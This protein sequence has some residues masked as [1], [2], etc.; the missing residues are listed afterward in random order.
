MLGRIGSIVSF[1]CLTCFIGCT[2]TPVGAAP[3]TD[4]ATTISV[5]TRSEYPNHPEVFWISF[6]IVGQVDDVKTW[7]T[8]SGAGLYYNYRRRRFELIGGHATRFAT[9]H[10]LTVKDV[11]QHTGAPIDGEDQ[12]VI[13]ATDFYIYDLE[14]WDDAQSGRASAIFKR[15]SSG[16]YYIVPGFTTRADD[17]GLNCFGLVVL[18]FFP[19]LAEAAGVEVDETG[20]CVTSPEA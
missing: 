16:A 20:I 3:P 9:T 19:K 10:K 15:L 18:D 13:I 1:L 6:D 14:E 8:N 17:Q 2:A 4:A 7:T 5:E 11:Y 12:L